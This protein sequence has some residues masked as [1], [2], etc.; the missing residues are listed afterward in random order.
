MA[1]K[2]TKYAKPAEVKREWF[3]VDATDLV[4][5]R[6]AT[7]VAKLLRGKHKVTYTPSTDVGDNIIVINAEKAVFTGNK[8]QDKQYFRHTGHPGGIKE[9]SPRLLHLEGKPERIIEK[10]VQRMIS[11]KDILGRNQFK[12]LFVYA[13]AEHPHTAQ[14]PK[15]LD[16]GAQNRKNKKTNQ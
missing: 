12:K 14:Q 15:T 7:E 13:G 2:A 3:L 16:I 5:G 9:A 1:Q 10:A 6:L 4:V 11:R 8:H